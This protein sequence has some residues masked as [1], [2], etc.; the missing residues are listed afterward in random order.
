MKILICDDHKIVRDGLRQILQHLGGVD[1][2]CEAGSV[3]ELMTLLKTE[4]FNLILLDISLPDRSGMEVIQSIKIKYPETAILMLSMMP[5]E[6]Y[7]L[8]SL[9]LGAS[10]Y[11]TKDTTAKE[12]LFAVQKILEGGKYIS[13][14]LA[15]SIAF[16]PGQASLQK[17]HELLSSREFDIMIKI[18]KGKKLKDIGDEIFISAK[19]VSSYRNRIMEKMELSTNSAIIRYCLDHKL[20]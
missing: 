11:L 13:P 8:H 19:T 12:L 16:N 17:T 5:Q 15:E 14:S 18:A 9:K 7:A 20:I 6:Q 1:L 4:S 3:K 2:I 10:G